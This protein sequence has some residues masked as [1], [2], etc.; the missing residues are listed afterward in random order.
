MEN[1][2]SEKRDDGK[3]YLC[4]KA[5]RELPVGERRKQDI[6]ESTSRSSR[7]ERL[8]VGFAGGTDICR[9]IDGYSPSLRV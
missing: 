9:S 5:V 1:Q 8:K 2:N 4:L 3:K 7:A 6:W